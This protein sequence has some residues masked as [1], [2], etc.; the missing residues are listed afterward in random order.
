VQA[1][2]A[3]GVWPPDAIHDAPGSLYWI[4]VWAALKRAEAEKLRRDAGL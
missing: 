2:E 4:A 1:A 3:F